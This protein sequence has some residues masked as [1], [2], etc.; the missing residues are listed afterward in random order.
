MD[1]NISEKPPAS[2]LYP[3]PIKYL[4]NCTAHFSQFGTEMEVTCQS[5]TSTSAHKSM[6]GQ[7]SE[8]N[9]LSVLMVYCLY[10]LGAFSR[11]IYRTHSHV[12]VLQNTSNV[13][14]IHL[15]K[16]RDYLYPS[17]YKFSNA[18]SF[19][20]LSIYRKAQTY[21]YINWSFRVVL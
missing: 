6:Q 19:S 3:F 12:T 20:F 4:Y 8:D 13:D 15:V 9:I 5:A 1:N 14:S 11:R 18:E 2:V 10:L 21:C 7:N 16:V 17:E